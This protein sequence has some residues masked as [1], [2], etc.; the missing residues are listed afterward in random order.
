MSLTLTPALCALLL[1]PHGAERYSCRAW[2]LVLG[3]FFRLFN[4]SFDVATRATRPASFRRYPA[5]RHCA[6]PP[7]GLLALTV[8]GF[9]RVPSGFI[10]SQEG[11]RLPHHRY[12]AAGGRLAFAN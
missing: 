11:F 7:A 12:G 1:R 10:P 5:Q 6:R 8:F 3:W 9:V 2:D 4:R